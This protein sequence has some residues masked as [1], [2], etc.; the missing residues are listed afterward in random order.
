MVHIRAVNDRLLSASGKDRKLLET[1]GLTQIAAAGALCGL[2]SADLEERLN[3]AGI[4]GRE[5]IE[6]KLRITGLIKADSS[7]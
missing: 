3:R 2:T 1:L 5:A 7:R 4:S 6:A